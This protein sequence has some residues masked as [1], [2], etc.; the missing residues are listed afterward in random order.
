M[1]NRL[2]LF[3]SGVSNSN[4]TS[5]RS[6]VRTKN[7]RSKVVRK[8]A[9]QNSFTFVQLED[10][11]LLAGVFL[12]PATDVLTMFGGSGDDD[13]QTAMV[14]S[15]TFSVSITGVTPTEFELSEVA[16]MVFIGFAG[17]DL[18]SNTTPISAQ[19]LGNGGNDQIFGGSGG[20]RIN[21]GPGDD[22]LFGRDGDDVMLGVSG[23]DEI[24]GEAGND[25]IYGSLTGT[26]DITGGV[27]D[28]I[29]FGGNVADTIDGGN[30]V[31]QIFGLAGDDILMSGAGGTAGTSGI[32][33]ADLILGLKGNDTIIGASGLDVLYGGDDDDTITGG[34]GENRIHGQH[35]ND[36]LTGGASS[37][38]ISGSIGNDVIDGKGADD[39]LLGGDGR[40][41][42]YG[43]GGVDSLFG[44]AG[45]DGLFAGGGSNE[46]LNGG[47]GV[48]RF[49]TVAGDSI[50]D[51]TA[52]ADAEI[53]F[54][55]DGSSWND[56]EIQTID[57]GFSLLH[58][59]VGSS[60]VFFNTFDPD[61]V[62]FYKVP[63]NS[64]GQGIDGFN[65]LKWEGSFNI[66]G[67]EIVSETYTRKIEVADWNE[68]IQEDNEWAALTGIHEL[69]HNF[70]SV[71]EIKKVL[72]ANGISNLWTQFLN[73][74]GWTS[75][76]PGGGHTQ[77]AGQTQEPFDRTWNPNITN[78]N[79]TKGNYD[80]HVRSWWYDNGTE[81]ARIY[82]TVNPQEDWAT[83]WE[84][85]FVSELVENVNGHSEPVTG[86]S[87][88]VD[89]LFSFL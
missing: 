35:G 25:K 88:L 31:D 30:D 1:L 89:A 32:A 22:V 21:G 42:L 36:I 7:G 13:I 78:S 83:I 34:S 41:D 70:D 74:S 53:K 3:S 60:R 58:A 64:L 50:A 46:S 67:G 62:T 56:K 40:D 10:R 9:K 73:T 54:K 59:K 72:P 28:D 43:G 20:D 75:T 76:N 14:D 82:G 23:D 6:V 79:G 55:N 81:F 85:F 61:P 16:S 2:N 26:N 51:F 87:N 49:L 45:N 69:S 12:D 18:L 24:H 57:K 65:T 48:D 77:A 47:A 68:S 19:M 52:S 84:S 33:N 37:D 71:E 44:G 80:F 39:Y 29:L 17:N 63:A 11:R 38:Y 8:Q 15:N 27:G 66:P 4:G 5:N 86:K